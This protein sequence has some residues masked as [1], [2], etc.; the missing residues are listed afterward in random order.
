LLG[1]WSS[2]DDGAL[3]KLFPLVQPELHRLAHHYMS[4][5][6]G[7]RR[8]TELQNSDELPGTRCR[9][10][11]HLILVR[12]YGLGRCVQFGRRLH[13][14]YR[15]MSFPLKELWLAVDEVVHHDDVMPAIIIWPRGNVA[16]FD[17]DP[18]NARVGKHDA[19]E[20]QA[21]ITRRSRDETAEQQIA[22]G[23]EVIDQRAGMAVSVFPARS[24]AIRLVNVC[25]DRA[26][27]SD[28]C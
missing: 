1:D 22:V 16:G 3:E 6:R 27:G 25:E 2:G 13:S 10:A 9:P 11:A 17:P 19:E 24:A 8:A 20:G 15:G 23:I 4:R 21:S 5:E 18:R 14:I 28:F 7:D 12:F 26:E